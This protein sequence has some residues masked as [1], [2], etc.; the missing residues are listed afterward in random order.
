M[1]MMSHRTLACLSGL[2]FI[3]CTSAATP[4]PIDPHLTHYVNA[5][6][7]TMDDSAP[8]ATSMV[9]RGSEIVAIGLNADLAERFVGANVVDLGG[10]FVLPGFVDSHVHVRELGLDAIKVDLVGVESMAEIVAR[11]REQ[12]PDVTPGEWIIGQGWDEG[13]FADYS[14][15]DKTVGGYPVTDRLSDA[16]PDNPIALESLHGFGAMTNAAGLE[17]AGI[18]ADTP[19]P[20]GETILRGADG[21]PTGVLLTLS[22]AL[23]FNV[24]PPPSPEQTE[25][26]IIAGLSEMARAGVTSI[27]EAGMTREDVLAFRN[28][29][30]RNEL[31]IRVVGMLNGNDVELMD[32]WFTSGPLD[33]PDDW[34]DINAIKVF[35]DGSLGSRTAMLHAPYSDKPDAA[36]PTA[37][38][39]LDAIDKLAVRA[40]ETG[41]QMAVHAIG[42]EAND[43]ILASYEL[44]LYPA[45][46]DHRWRIEHAQVLSEDFFARAAALNVIA[47]MQPSHAMGDSP[48]AEERVGPVR[49]QRA[50]AWDSLREAGVPLIFNSDLPGEPWE[51]MQ[52]LHFAAT[53]TK[54][55]GSPIGGWYANEALSR[56]DALKA[57]TIDGAH[58]AFQDNRLGSLEPGKWAD[59]VILSDNPL[60]TQ[61]VRDIGVEATYV[62]GRRV[63]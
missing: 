18:S 39:H 1:K 34:L 32:E 10:K 20:Q 6:F 44:R 61:D 31:P 51:P 15:N 14:G 24:V 2:F 55:D 58:A 19:D 50:Y 48:W 9:V 49:I 63:H 22:Q 37:R 59:F 60:T 54:L 25:A 13:A 4:E 52:T 53:R 38:I 33:D 27:H 47:S 5:T 35:F 11:I 36:K 26:A 30:A 41:F 23:L 45:D 56:E 40:V 43:C 7:V 16:F 42:D 8:H 28:V 17:R 29:A 46:Y 57:M 3:A 21:S 12:R 62:A